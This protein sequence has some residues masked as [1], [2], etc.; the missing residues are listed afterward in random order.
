MI[1]SFYARYS[2]PLLLF[3]CATLVPLGYYAETLPNNNDIET[4]LPQTSEVMTEY[5]QFKEDFGS[6][7]YVLLAI[8]Q[9]T[10]TDSFLN[11]LAGRIER[12]PSVEQCWSP[13]RFRRTNGRNG[14]HKRRY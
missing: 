1:S 4:W 6:E 9:R 8:P 12:L 14:C 13:A 5:Q 10:N 7:E 3:A 11:S 2:L